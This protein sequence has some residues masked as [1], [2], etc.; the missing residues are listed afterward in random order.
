M[1]RRGQAFVVHVLSVFAMAH[2]LS[3][4]HKG[5]IDVTVV[6]K[7]CQHPIKNVIAL[8]L[9]IQALTGSCACMM[10]SLAQDIFPSTRQCID[11]HP[12]KRALSMVFLPM[13]FVVSSVYWSLLIF[14]PSLILIPIQISTTSSSPVHSLMRLPLL[15]DLAMHLA[16]F[17]SLL[18]DF[19][20]FEPKFSRR[21][22]AIA[23]IMMIAYATV[24]A[25]ALEYFAARNDFFPYPFLN[26]S[27]LPIRLAIYVGTSCTGLGCLAFLNRLHSAGR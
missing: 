10:L 14:A 5:S 7:I 6:G 18:T 8:Y 2:G 9:T 27:T 25:G 19:A 24:Y 4:T 15:T 20:L 3:Y 21:Q 1:S 23:P 17:L 26:A 16:P 13:G 12:L 22:M 11:L